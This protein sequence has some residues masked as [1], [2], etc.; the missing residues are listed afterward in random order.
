MKS[1]KKTPLRRTEVFTSE[2]TKYDPTV[3]DGWWKSIKF[4]KLKKGDI[5]RLWETTEFGKEVPFPVKKG[6][7]VVNVALEDAQP[8]PMPE[9]GRI[10]CIEVNGFG[11][12]Q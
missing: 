11:R 3:T 1:I 7:H 4:N 10:Q 6:Q 2:D 9:L 5:F 8:R 12:E